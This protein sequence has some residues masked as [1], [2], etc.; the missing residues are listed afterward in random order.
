MSEK[1]YGNV[2]DSRRDDIK[3]GLIVKVVATRVQENIKDLAGDP[4]PHDEKTLEN[5]VEQYNDDL[6]K[7]YNDTIVN[8]KRVPIG[9]ILLEKILG[10]PRED[11]SIE[12][13]QLAPVQYEHSN[14]NTDTLGRVLGSL[15][16]G[17]WCGKRAIF[18]N[19]LIS[20]EEAIKKIENGILHQVSIGYD[21]YNDGR[22]KLHDISFTLYGAIPESNIIAIQD[23]SARFQYSANKNASNSIN[24]ISIRLSEIHKERIAIRKRKNLLQDSQSSKNI[25]HYLIKCGRISPRFKEMLVND[26]CELSTSK[27]RE[28]VV[29]MFSTM[30]S[31]IK[32]P[33]RDKSSYTLD[34]LMM[35]N[36][37]EEY[38]NKYIEKHGL[39]SVPVRLS[40]DEQVKYDLKKKQAEAEYAQDIKLSKEL[41][42][43]AQRYSEHESEKA[44]EEVEDHEFGPKHNARFHDRMKSHYKSKDYEKIG[45]EYCKF[46]KM[47][48][49][50]A[51]VAEPHQIAMNEDGEDFMD[52]EPE[53]N[54]IMSLDKK[55]A[56]LEHE[57]DDLH[58]Q[59]KRCREEMEEM[60]EMMR[61]HFGRN[62]EYSEHHE[63]EHPKKH[64]EKSKKEPKRMN[65]E[66]EKEDDEKDDEK[67]LANKGK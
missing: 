11:F 53:E 62:K 60:K 20:D 37:L 46:H 47:S 1:L 7:E 34:E 16:L 32:A 36:T 17:K 48:M 29:R 66:D 9:K 19:L 38:M 4:K 65:K 8:K 44:I 27:D 13:I 41:R 64:T 39:T 10:K 67:E 61:E 40:F 26:L 30:S 54:E 25:A 12:D 3:S 14:N 59:I 23:S 2:I 6:A 42:F 31:E 35:S 45:K 52:D 22:Y 49:D 15:R 57:E 51:E 43:S 55:D 28:I 56:E 24:K 5:I 50:E 33:R 21:I 18:A 63:N 58:E